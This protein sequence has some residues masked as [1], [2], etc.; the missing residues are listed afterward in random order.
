MS[1]L[2][3]RPTPGEQI[4]ISWDAKYGKAKLDDVKRMLELFC[5]CVDSRE[6]IPRN[7]A[8][9]FRD[10]FR[11]YLDS[12]GK[13]NIEHSLGLKRKKGR[14]EANNSDM[15]VD[16][17]RFRM[18]GKSHQDS[19]ALVSER[20]NYSESVIQAAWKVDQFYAYAT[21][22]KERLAEGHPWTEEEKSRLINLL[23]EDDSKRTSE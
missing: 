21:L 6:E 13:V 19:L 9:Y 7:L 1:I 2:K 15:A 3:T 22:T 12:D 20:F 17:L 10:S 5:E 23:H 14:P 18:Q 16:F 4:Q 8:I 11:R